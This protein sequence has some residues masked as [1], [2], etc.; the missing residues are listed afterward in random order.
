MLAFLNSLQNMS[1]S[2]ISS[3]TD[4]LSEAVLVT[5]V[6][7]VGT[8]ECSVESMMICANISTRESSEGY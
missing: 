8:G 2:T 1:I 5:G 3:Y 4:F 6:I 7:V